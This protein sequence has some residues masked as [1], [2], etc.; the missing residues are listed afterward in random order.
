MGALLDTHALIWWLVGDGRISPKLRQHLARPG[1]PVFVSA[2]TACEIATKAR[3]GKLKAPQ[4]LF[5]DFVEA[6]EMLGF[7]A[8][9]SFCGMAMT[10]AGCLPPIAIP[11]IA[12]SPPRRKPKDWIW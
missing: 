12:C 11:S 9:R 1:Q 2:A 4:T 3:I 7:A 10:R 5:E 6:I 8:L